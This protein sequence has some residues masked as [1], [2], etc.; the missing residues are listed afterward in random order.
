MLAS[1]IQ[2]G[3]SLVDRRSAGAKEFDQL[4]LGRGTVACIASTGLRAGDWNG[5]TRRCPPS[6]PGAPIAVARTTSEWLRGFRR[7]FPALRHRSLSPVV[8]RPA[9]QMRGVERR[10]RRGARVLGRA[11]AA[12]ARTRVRAAHSCG[13]MTVGG[14]WRRVSRAG[15]RLP[16]LMLQDSCRMGRH[17]GR[18][19]GPP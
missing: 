19:H 11:G 7:R 3:D 4:I 14:E 6:A 1:S 12:T 17:P 10:R 2:P 5:A 15:V 9:L 8:G 18:P 16:G 13:L